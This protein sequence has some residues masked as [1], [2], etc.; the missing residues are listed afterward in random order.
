MTK[1]LYVVCK[2]AFE[3]NDET[4]DYRGNGPPTTYFHNK[5]DAEKHAL[6]LSLKQARNLGKTLSYMG[7][8]CTEEI[9]TRKGLNII[10]KLNTEYYDGEEALVDLEDD[11]DLSTLTDKQLRLILPEMTHPLFSVYEVE[12]DLDE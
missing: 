6:E 5:E 4:Y 11:I 2:A 1:K 8:Y 10:S 12:G 3:Y 9:F 7:G